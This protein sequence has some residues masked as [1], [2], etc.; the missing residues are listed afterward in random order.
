[1]RF[2]QANTTGAK[3]VPEAALPRLVKRPKSARFGALQGRRRGAIWSLLSPP[4]APQ[5]PPIVQDKELAP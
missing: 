1:M 4:P 5:A 2:W 3:I